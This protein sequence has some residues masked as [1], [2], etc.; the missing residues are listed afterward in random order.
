MPMRQ[1]PELTRHASLLNRKSL[2]SPTSTFTPRLLTGVAREKWALL[3][4]TLNAAEEMVARSLPGKIF[5][6]SLLS[7]SAPADKQS[8]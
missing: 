3:L 1:T 4:G 8:S 6:V 5:V 2:R 7:S